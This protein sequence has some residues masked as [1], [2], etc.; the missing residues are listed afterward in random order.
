MARRE[1]E[2]KQLQGE[3]A[4]LPAPGLLDSVC[5]SPP[6]RCRACAFLVA[7]SSARRSRMD[8]KQPKLQLLTAMHLP[9]VLLDIAF[10]L[11]CLDF[12]IQTCALLIVRWWWGRAWRW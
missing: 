3:L 5:Q 9:L 4:P 12:K 2:M 1:Q 6:C 11:A 10:R 7:F 8:W